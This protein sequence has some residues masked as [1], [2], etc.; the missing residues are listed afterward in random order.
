MTPEERDRDWQI[1]QAETLYDELKNWWDWDSEGLVIAD[2]LEEVAV[3]EQEL[4]AERKER[5]TTR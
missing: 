1:R 2:Q 5:R 4:V 3:R